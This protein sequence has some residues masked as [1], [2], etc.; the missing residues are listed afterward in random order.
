V[1][2]SKKY[3]GSQNSAHSCQA[4]SLETVKYWN[5]YSGNVKEF[6]SRQPK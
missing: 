5:H 1:G 2:T 3:L 6:V 4:A